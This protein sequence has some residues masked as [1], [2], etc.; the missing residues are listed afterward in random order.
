MS[1]LTPAPFD[2]DDN[3]NLISKKKVAHNKTQ[4]KYTKS[5]FDTEKVTSMMKTIHENSNAEDSNLADFNPPQSAISMGAER[6]KLNRERESMQNI[7]SFNAATKPEYSPDLGNSPSPM[8]NNDDLDLTNFKT[9]YGTDKSI[10]EYYKKF[11]PNYSSSKN[12]HGERSYPYATANAQPLQ[13]YGNDVLLAK[14][15]Y[16]INLLEE[17]QDERTNNVTEEVVLYSFLGIFIIFIVDSFTRIG[18]Y[19]R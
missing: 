1:L 9:N 12:A 6:A 16:M 18:K 5:D 13:S 14:L 10:E 17:K 8:E 19:V 2:N 7:E 4:K 15:N 11:I 3:E